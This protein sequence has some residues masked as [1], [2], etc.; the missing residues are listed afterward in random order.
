MIRI[1]PKAE[2]DLEQIYEYTA[3]RW[4][5]SQAEKYQDLLFD[6]FTRISSHNLIGKA[7]KTTAYDYRQV[8]IGRHLIFYR[9]DVEYI[10]VVRVL[11]DKMDIAK[12][13]D[14]R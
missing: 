11:H 12:H 1:S 2:E 5:L 14:D 10:I 6:A 3:D 7:F 9:Y 8:H 13:V 4:G